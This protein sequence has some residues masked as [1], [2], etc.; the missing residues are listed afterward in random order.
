MAMATAIV[1]T[2]NVAAAIVAVAVVA[3]LAK[4]KQLSRLR[5]TWIA[6]QSAGQLVGYSWPVGYSQAVG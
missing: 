4:P 2:A 1:S 6:S 5:R 3:E